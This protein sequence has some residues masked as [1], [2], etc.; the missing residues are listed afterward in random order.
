MAKRWAV[1]N[2]RYPGRIWEPGRDDFRRAVSARGGSFLPDQSRGSDCWTTV[3]SEHES[4]SIT[5]AAIQ[6]IRS[7][8]R[9]AAAVVIGLPEALQVEVP[10]TPPGN[11]MTYRSGA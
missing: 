3:V 6:G 9:E 5:D 11:L 10:T 7:L 2:A 4:E 8:E 1:V